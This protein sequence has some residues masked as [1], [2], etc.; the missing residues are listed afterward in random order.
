MSRK[1]ILFSTTRQWNP[2]DEFILM[3]ILNLFRSLLDIN[4]IIFNRTPEIQRHSSRLSFDLR[5]DLAKVTGRHLKP[6]FFDNSYK[7][8]LLKERF[9]DMAVLAGTPEW[10]SPRLDS[11]YDYVEKHAVPLL[12]LGIG[13]GFE[14][15]RVIRNI[16]RTHGRFLKRARLIT[17]RDPFCRDMLAEYHPILLSCPS[18]LAAPQSSERK[19]AGVKRVALIYSTNHSVK[20]N[21]IDKATY[22]FMRKLYELFMEKYGKRFEVEMVCHYINGLAQMRKDFPD[23]PVE[24]Y[25][26]DSRDYIDIYNRFDFVLGPRVHGIGLSASMGIPGVC[27]RHDIRGRTV[28]GFLAGTIHAGMSLDEAMGVVDEY[29]R[30]VPALNERLLALKREVWAQYIA[31]LSK[32]IN[33]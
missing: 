14:D 8:Q 18:L 19:I 10:A 28:E 6:G 5:I 20:F 27:I 32:A 23:I 26:Y 24:H 1:N 21:R 13:S 22:L 11:F 29:I 25:S 15:K 12:Y 33:S 30:D 3:G 17:V 9:I 4:P 2:G 7:E 16:K 31:L